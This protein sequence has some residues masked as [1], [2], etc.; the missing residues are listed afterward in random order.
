MK[1]LV[2]LPVAL[3]VQMRSSKLKN[4]KIK[5]PFLKLRR[6]PLGAPDSKIEK[7]RDFRFLYLMVLFS[8]L[9][10]VVTR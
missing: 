9:A 3:N 6:K 2:V 10:S 5:Y 7:I 1:H 4:R 8:D